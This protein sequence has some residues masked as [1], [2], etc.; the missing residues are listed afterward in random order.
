VA[1]KK[2]ALAALLAGLALTVAG[3]GGSGAPSVAN[4][5]TTTIATAT[6]R[7]SNVAVGSVGGQPSS[8]AGAKTGAPFSVAGAVQQMTKFAVCMRA[9]GEPSLPD[10]NGQGVISAAFNRASPQFDQALRACRKD[11]PGGVQS[12]AQQAADARQAVAFSN[13]MRRNGV[14]NPQK[15]A[16]GGMVIDVVN[17]DPNSPQFQRAHAICQKRFPG[18]GKG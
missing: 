16:D 7:N 14:P 1:V 12:P 13:C 2:F 9:N 18:R 4:L 10:P 11:L 8:S 5:G 15:G 6:A 3:C 17:V